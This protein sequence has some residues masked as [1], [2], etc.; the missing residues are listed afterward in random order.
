MPPPLPKGGPLGLRLGSPA[1][2]VV[3]DVYVDFC[4]PFSAIVYNRLVD[5]VIPAFAKRSEEALQV[6]FYQVPQPWHPQ[7]TMMHEAVIGAAE[8]SGNYAAAYAAMFAN[9]EKFVDIE[10]FDKTRSEIYKE[11]AEVIYFG[12][13]WLATLCKV[14]FILTQVMCSS[15]TGAN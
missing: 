10:T 9:R 3:L 5:D 6:V 4:C 15:M 13:L 7:G 2:K 8:L 12:I 14:S 1:A 11:L